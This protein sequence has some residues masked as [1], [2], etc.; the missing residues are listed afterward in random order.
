MTRLEDIKISTSV[1]GLAGSS[2]VNVV[3]VKWYGN[4]VLYD[5]TAKAQ[6]DDEAAKRQADT[7]LR[8]TNGSI[9]PLTLIQHESTV[10]CRSMS[11][12]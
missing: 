2:P 10:I 4:A 8:N 1:T 12:K 9:Y 11:R 7:S 6:I 3:A 5:G